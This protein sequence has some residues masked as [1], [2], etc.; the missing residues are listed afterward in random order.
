MET[1]AVYILL[2]ASFIVGLL[3]GTLV[4]LHDEGTAALPC[5]LCLLIAPGG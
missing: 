4:D 1:K 3:I 5:P 2:T